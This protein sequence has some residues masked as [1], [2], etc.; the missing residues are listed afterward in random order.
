MSF[1]RGKILLVP[2]RLFS[3]KRS[4]F[5][6]IVKTFLS[7]EMYRVYNHLTLRLKH[8]IFKLRLLKSGT[9]M[10]FDKSPLIWSFSKKGR[11]QGRKNAGQM[12]SSRG[13][14]HR[15]SGF[16][17][18]PKSCRVMRPFVCLEFF[19]IPFSF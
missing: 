10:I 7:S 1:I 11:E 3:G 13:R 17:I 4:S 8:Y 16:F 18:S 12:L 6:K 2:L 15:T 14:Q 5:G 19:I 9:R